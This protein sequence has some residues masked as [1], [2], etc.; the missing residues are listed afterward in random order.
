MC[1][2]L[3]LLTGRP[4][5]SVVLAEQE[6]HLWATVGDF[7]TARGQPCITTKRVRTPALKA[8]S[9]RVCRS[10]SQVS[11]SGLT[12]RGLS[13]YKVRCE[14]KCQSTSYSVLGVC[15][16]NLT[17]NILQA[18]STCP[19]LISLTTMG[20]SNLQFRSLLIAPTRRRVWSMVP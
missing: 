15:T 18:A 5:L 1:C 7:W 14:G 12:T 9:F 11:Y 20:M 10:F 16:P 13:A 4:T 8:P 19:A 2:L 3:Y 6:M 17:Y